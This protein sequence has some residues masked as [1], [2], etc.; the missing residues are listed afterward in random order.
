MGRPLRITSGGL[1]YH[2]LNRANARMGIF[3]QP[4]DYAAF[5][6]ILEQAVARVKG[7]QHIEPPRKCDDELA[8]GRNLLPDALHPA[9]NWLIVDKRRLPN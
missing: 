3:D 6:R 9:T 8:V 4:D 1:V 5:E 7:A 2:V